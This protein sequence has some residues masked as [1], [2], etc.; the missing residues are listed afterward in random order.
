MDMILLKLD[1]TQAPAS[2]E[3]TST[4]QSKHT[5][6]MLQHLVVRI[7]LSS[8]EEYERL[9]EAISSSGDKGIVSLVGR[10][11]EVECRWRIAD[12]SSSIS[13]GGRVER[14]TYRLELEQMEDLQVEKLLVDG[15]EFKPY[16]YR[17]REEIGR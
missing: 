10:S 13:Q 8:E 1:D 12:N 15:R 4:F 7:D 5:G 6:A 11:S 3:E 2:I 17:E 9:G 16:A 14:Y